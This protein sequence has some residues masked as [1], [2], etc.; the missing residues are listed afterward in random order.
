MFAALCA[1][2]SWPGEEVAPHMAQVTR[3]AVSPRAVDTQPGTQGEHVERLIQSVNI[4]KVELYPYY[5][6]EAIG[7]NMLFLSFV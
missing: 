7:A 2:G 1:G 4:C 5:K 6:A 3:V